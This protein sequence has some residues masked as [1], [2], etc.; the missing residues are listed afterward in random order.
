MK[1]RFYAAAFK[2]ALQAGVRLAQAIELLQGPKNDGAKIPLL[3]RGWFAAVVTLGAAIV[4]MLVWLHECEGA[5][6][7]ISWDAHPDAEVTQ[8]RV[9]RFVG[10]QRVLIVAT[11]STEAVIEAETGEAI[12]VTAVKGWEESGLSNPIVVPSP[13]PPADATRATLQRSFDLL[14]WADLVSTHD[15]HV[16]KVFYR[17]QVESLNGTLESVY[18]LKSPPP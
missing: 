17:L 16:E 15:P 10:G 6:R 13:L 12:A 1:A 8:Y 14:A 18:V 5:E 7:S 3:E 2:M 4:A 9:W 11:N